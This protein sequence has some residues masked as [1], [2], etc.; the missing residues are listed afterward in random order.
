MLAP[1]GAAR[2]RTGDDDMAS[3]FLDPEL[4]IPQFE[5]LLVVVH[6]H[7]NPDAVERAVGGERMR[8]GNLVIRGRGATN[9]VEAANH[10]GGGGIVTPAPGCGESWPP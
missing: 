4:G 9:A 2:H 1:R 3:G 5:I 8:H 7:Q 10:A 6:E